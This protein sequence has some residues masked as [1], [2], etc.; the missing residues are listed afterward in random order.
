MLDRHPDLTSE[1]IFGLGWIYALLFTMNIWWTFRS[2][3][4]DGH[5]RIGSQ[6]VPWAAFWALYCGVL[7]MISIAHL[8]GSGSPEGFPMRLPLV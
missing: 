3:R 6:R 5:V 7:F 2:L 4:Q 1:V 8:T